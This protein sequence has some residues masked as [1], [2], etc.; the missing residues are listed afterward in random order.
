MSLKFRHPLLHSNG[1]LL[2]CHYCNKKI[3]LKVNQT[4]NYVICGRSP[5]REFK[6]N[7][8][9]LLQQTMAGESEIYATKLSRQCSGGRSAQSE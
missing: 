7:F 1:C 3:V 5:R 9:Y 6:R 4:P 8:H 2:Q